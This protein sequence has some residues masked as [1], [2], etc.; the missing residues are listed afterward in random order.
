MRQGLLLVAAVSMIS[1]HSNS[2]AQVQEAGK[3]TDTEA[4]FQR[5]VEQCDNVDLL[6]L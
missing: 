5:L 6:M 1:A 2:F 4:A 3:L